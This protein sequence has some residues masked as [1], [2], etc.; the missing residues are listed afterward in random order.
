MSEDD[1]EHNS[2]IVAEILNQSDRGCAIVGTAYI[3]DQLLLALRSTLATG[4]DADDLFKQLFGSHGALG[5]ARPRAEIGM[6]TGLYGPATLKDLVRMLKIRNRFAHWAL[7]IDFGD[8]EV[9]AHCENLG[10]RAR[11]WKGN[12]SIKLRPRPFDPATARK[13]FV[14]CVAIFAKYLGVVSK[15]NTR[16]LE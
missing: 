1:F 13:E 6:L 7:P 11:Y 10:L 2:E 9:R 12:S 3:E 16:R 8:S 5:A 14:S 15:G 4:A